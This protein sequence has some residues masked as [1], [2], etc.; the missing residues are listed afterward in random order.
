[1]NGGTNLSGLAAKARRVLGT[2][3]RSGIGRNIVSLYGLQVANYFLPLITVPYLVRVLGPEKFGVVAFAQS[4]VALLAVVINFGFDWSAT[5]SISVHRASRAE[6][7]RIASTVWVAKSLLCAGGSLILLGLV[8]FV[9]KL[10]DV[11][12]LMLV[13]YGGAV[14]SVVSPFWLLQ[15]LERLVPASV[16][17]ASASLARVVAIFVFVRKPSDFLL[18]AAINSL[19]TIA[20]AIGAVV[21][22]FKVLGVRIVRP[23]W[24]EICR[25]LKESWTL[26][27]SNSAIT[28]YTTANAFLLGLL[29]NHTVVGY[30]SAAE[31]LIRGVSG[32]LGPVSQAAYPRFSK[33][34]AESTEKA[35]LWGG[36]MLKFMAASGLLL[37]LV[38]FATAGLVVR[39]VLGPSYE[40]S[41]AVLRLLA[42]VPF[43]VAISNVL[44][45]Q[46]MFPFRREKA[47]LL[48]VTAAGV[49]NL[50][51]AMVLAPAFGARGM[52]LA[53]LC[54][55]VFVTTSY[56]AFLWSVGLNPLR[57]GLEVR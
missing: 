7:N 9:P 6:V 32:L 50:V 12:V 51:L 45:V 31:R 35:L 30:Y 47:V 41:V 5:R 53:V 22:S 16:M 48:L 15:G 42:P 14:G 24:G 26:F 13:V 23:S 1:M 39:I 34:A 44:G 10:H 37:S 4:L 17:S 36:R 11:S 55:E 18:Y 54:S 25:T 2:S 29:T 8:G 21:F 52:A 19:Q 27:L 43:L 40:P 57:A 49:I 56:F 28:L 46:V 20:A 33:I 38:L 3:L